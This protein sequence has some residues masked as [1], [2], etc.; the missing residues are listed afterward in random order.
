ML[1][2]TNSANFEFLK[3]FKK[4]YLGVME[5]LCQLSFLNTDL[6]SF[7]V[8]TKPIKKWTDWPEELIAPMKPF[9]LTG[10][11]ISPG[12]FTGGIP[13]TLA[14]AMAREVC[15]AIT[16]FSRLLFSFFPLL[17]LLLRQSNSGP[18]HGKR[19]LCCHHPPP[20]PYVFKVAFLSIP[21]LG[22]SSNVGVF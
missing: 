15:V 2:G 22:L 10:G 17:R 13:A 21:L 6:E 3:I 9:F 11:L 14:P 12:T 8:V 20:E 18:C 7:F 5:H 1:A 19:S 16:L 4:L